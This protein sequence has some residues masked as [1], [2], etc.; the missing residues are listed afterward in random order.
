MI[1]QIG[2]G[3]SAGRREDNARHAPSGSVRLTQVART[4][5]EEISGV[6]SL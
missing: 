6:A 4:L 1:S 2:A 3:T 5:D